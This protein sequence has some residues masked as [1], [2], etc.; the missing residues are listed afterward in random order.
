[1]SCVQL[2]SNHSKREDHDSSSVLECQGWR[3]LWK[4][5]LEYPHHVYFKYLELNYPLAL[6]SEDVLVTSFFSPSGLPGQR[7]T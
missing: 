7:F 2:P 6:E 4:K 5:Y 1:M 3:K